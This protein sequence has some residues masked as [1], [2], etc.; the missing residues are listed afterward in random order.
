MFQ[1]YPSPDETKDHHNISEIITKLIITTECEGK[2][3]ASNGDTD[4]AARF[5]GVF[6]YLCFETPLP[7]TNN[8]EYST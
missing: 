1:V 3:L 5:A 4:K 8:L 2:T 7:T 6:R